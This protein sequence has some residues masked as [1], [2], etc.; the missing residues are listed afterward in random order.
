MLNSRFDIAMLYI[1]G[2]FSAPL[3]KGSKILIASRALTGLRQEETVT[4]DD[5]TDLNTFASAE[6]LFD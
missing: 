4:L 2:E 5:S 1:F 6:V 3:Y